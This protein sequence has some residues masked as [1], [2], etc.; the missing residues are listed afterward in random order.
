MY[1]EVGVVDVEDSGFR[2]QVSGK[3]NRKLKPEH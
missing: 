2:C 3:K 1:S